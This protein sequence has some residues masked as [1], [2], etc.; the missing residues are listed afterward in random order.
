MFDP[1]PAPQ[2]RILCVLATVDTRG[3]LGHMLLQPLRAAART[4]RLSEPPSSATPALSSRARAIDAA[5]VYPV[6]RVQLIVGM[7]TLDGR[8]LGSASKR[9]YGPALRA[10]SAPL[11]QRPTHF[12][13][14]SISVEHTP[15]NQ[16][17]HMGRHSTS[18]PFFVKPAHAT[19]RS[20]SVQQAHKEPEIIAFRQSGTGTPTRHS[21]TISRGD[22]K[23]PGEIISLTTESMGTALSPDSFSATKSE[24]SPGGSVSA[25]TGQCGIRPPPPPQPKGLLSCLFG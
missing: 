20:K 4:A 8:G 24:S 22:E 5:R 7:P 19:H 6:L 15:V 3:H 21:C 13:I 11:Q 18:N 25:P 2:S 14:S 10:S 17:L 23:H 12:D 9:D 1:Q 16:L